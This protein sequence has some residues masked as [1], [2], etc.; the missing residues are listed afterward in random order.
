MTYAPPR[1]TYSH[2]GMYMQEKLQV[3]PSPRGL[4]PSPECLYLCRRNAFPPPR[5]WGWPLNLHKMRPLPRLRQCSIF[6]F[7]VHPGTAD[8]KVRLLGQK[9]GRKADKRH[10]AQ[11]SA[12]RLGGKK[13]FGNFAP[14][15]E[16]RG[17]PATRWRDSSD[18]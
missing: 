14:A 8:E 9:A 2:A 15:N 3:S 18:G 5:E 4:F 13:Y 16:K 11:K 12:G 6:L 17:H 1:C 7:S 10:F